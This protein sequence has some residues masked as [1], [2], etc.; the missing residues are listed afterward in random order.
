MLSSTGFSLFFLALFP[1]LLAGQAVPPRRRAARALPT[2]TDE[3]AASSYFIFAAAAT[4]SAAWFL[5]E[6]SSFLGVVATCPSRRCANGCSSAL[7][8][9]LPG[10]TLFPKR[11]H[12]GAATIGRLSW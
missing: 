8:L 5:T 6:I 3:R 9:C 1:G 2:S 12:A 11:R 10:V 4:L 7:S